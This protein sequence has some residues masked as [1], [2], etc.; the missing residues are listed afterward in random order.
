MSCDGLGRGLR[1]GTLTEVP[2]LKGD[3]TG[4]DV[5]LLKREAVAGVCNFE[6]FASILT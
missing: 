5:T 1:M 6:D 4:D 2:D 3:L